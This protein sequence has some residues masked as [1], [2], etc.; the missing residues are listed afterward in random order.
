MC[1]VLRGPQE[2]F[3][4]RGAP[5]RHFML[6]NSPPIADPSLHSETKKARKFAAEDHEEGLLDIDS[7]RI[8]SKTVQD[9]TPQQ[10]NVVDCGVTYS[11][12]LGRK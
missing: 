4:I 5:R 6:F 2:I 11:T 12:Y 8:V 9:E 10:D 7:W 1:T 3:S